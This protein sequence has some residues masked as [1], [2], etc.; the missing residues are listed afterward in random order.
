[1]RFRSP[2]EKPIHMGLTSG[3]TFIVGPDPTEVPPMFQRDAVLAGCEV[4]GSALPL[5]LLKARMEHEAANE[6]AE[7]AVAQEQRTSSRQL[8]LA[9]ARHRTAA[10]R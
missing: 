4:V 10:A 2:T 5:E 9:Q 1:M 8:L 7:A 3:H 6:I